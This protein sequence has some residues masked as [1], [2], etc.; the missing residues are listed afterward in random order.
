M[1][2]MRVVFNLSCV[3]TESGESGFSTTYCGYPKAEA[4]KKYNS[5]A[6]TEM[7][8]K[9]LPDMVKA[10]AEPISSIKDIKIYSSGDSN[11]EGVASQ[12]TGMTPTVIKQV[13]DLVKD[14]TGVNLSDVMRAN[15]YDAKVNR[16]VN[17]NGIE[18]ALL[19]TEASDK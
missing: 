17:V 5:A 4:Y 2:L 14:T 10:A 3:F 7:V 15:T 8:V 12:V 11:G 18:T 16:N 9:I 1:C 6:M 19:T 13:F